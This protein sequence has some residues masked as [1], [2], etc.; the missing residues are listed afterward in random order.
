VFTNYHSGGGELARAEQPPNLC[1]KLPKSQLTQVD[2]NVYVR[3]GGRGEETLIVWGPVAGEKCVVDPKS[4]A[5]LQKY[6]PAFETHGHVL[7]KVFGSI[8][9]SPIL[10]LYSPGCDLPATIA[11]PEQVRLLLGWKS[12]GRSGAHRP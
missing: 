9:K 10:G 8:F 1:E 2:G 5:E 3:M 11:L 7:D 4:L 12:R 6:Q